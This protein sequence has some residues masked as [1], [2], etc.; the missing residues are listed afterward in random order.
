MRIFSLASLTAVVGLCWTTV[1]Q[2]QSCAVSGQIEDALTGE[3]LV[4]AYVG[5]GS[6]LVSTD[7]T[8]SFRL[9]IP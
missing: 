5:V 8:G 9:N 4:G 1:A 2:A 7:A 6:N 3:P